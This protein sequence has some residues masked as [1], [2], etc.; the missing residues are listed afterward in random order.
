MVALSVLS[1]AI[2]ETQ[3]TFKDIETYAHV[4][5]TLLVL[6]P[7]NIQPTAKKTRYKQR[8]D[9]RS[10][11]AYYEHRAMAEWKLGRPLLPGEVVHHVN[12]DRRDNHPDNIWVF[13][14]QRA[15]MIFHHYTWQEE[16]GIKHL[17][18]I[19][20]VLRG[21]GESFLK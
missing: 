6:E 4:E 2:T 16:R 13:S 20:E 10:K 21:W 17:F 3:E 15:H 1:V 19:D 18:S 9:P 12:G 5:P 14:S 7:S 11:E 8:L